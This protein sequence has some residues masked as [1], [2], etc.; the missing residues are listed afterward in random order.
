MTQ[1][2]KIIGIWDPRVTVRVLKYF[3][4][5][6]LEVYAENLQVRNDISE[7]RIRHWMENV[8]EFMSGLSDDNLIS[9]LHIPAIYH[10]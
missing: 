2:N 4:P 10:T 1:I 5:R 8:K 6:H 3:G 9:C 7:L